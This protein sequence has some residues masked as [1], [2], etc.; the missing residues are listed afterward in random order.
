[1]LAAFASALLLKSRHSNRILMK[2]SSAGALSS[3]T[4][5][6]PTVTELTLTCSDGLKLAA[7]KWTLEHPDNSHSSSRST[8]SRNILCLHGWMDNCASFNRLAPC[9]L[10]QLHDDA[11]STS[12]VTLIALDLPGHGWSDHRS[13][14]GPPTVLAETAFYVAE[15]VRC[16]EWNS[17][18]NSQESPEASSSPSNNSNKFTLIGHSMGAAIGCIYTAAFPEQVDQLVLLE[19]A[20][21]LARHADDAIRHVRQHVQRRQAALLLDKQPRVYPDLQTAIATRCQTARN[22]PGNQ[23]LSEDAA[24]DLVVRGSR[25]VDSTSGALVFRHDARLQWPSIQYWTADM[26]RIMYRDMQTPTCLLLA[27][28]GWP[29]QT[30]TTPASKKADRKDHDD[31]SSMLSFDAMMELLQPQVF[32]TLPGSHHFHADPD[33]VDAVADRVVQFLL[34]MAPSASGSD[35]SSR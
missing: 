17:N 15:A 16:L 13:I 19:G 9:L 11:S 1:M 27:H 7:Q 34:T 20:G 8:S 29:L 18:S 10:Q 32:E 3:I 26:N 22:F 31:D 2:A 14:D 23:Y 28:D 12:A 6:P 4:M 25:V 35:S 5:T 30:P 24:R 33:S 21:P